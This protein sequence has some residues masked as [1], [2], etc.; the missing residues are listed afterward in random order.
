MAGIKE[1]RPAVERVKPPG[2]IIKVGN[3]IVGWLPHSRLHG[4]VDE[5]LM[6]LR[7]RGLH[8]LST[9][10]QLQSSRSPG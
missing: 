1:K 8:L 6:L 3:P 9:F 10:P 5:H 4:L 2:V 7:F